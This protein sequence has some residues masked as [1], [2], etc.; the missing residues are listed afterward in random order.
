MHEG[1][2][3]AH[4]RERINGDHLFTWQLSIANLKHFAPEGLPSP[5]F[6][7]LLA[8]DATAIDDRTIDAF[9]ERLL[10]HGMAYLC[11]W[12]PDCR[13]VHDLVDDVVVLRTI[14]EG[15]E[16]TIMTTWHDDEPLEEA[17]WFLIHAAY[18][19]EALLPTCE[20]RIG[21]AVANDNWAEE[22]YRRFDDATECLS[23]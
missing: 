8:V 17:I 22:L 15:W 16:H 11:V 2:M 13:R 14:R 6:A 21:I 3:V 18:P 5:H 1:G 9:A 4:G 12:G 20:T 7:C 10:D 23:P 19:E